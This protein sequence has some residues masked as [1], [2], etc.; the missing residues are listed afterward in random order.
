MIFAGYMWH[1]SLSNKL[2]GKEIQDKGQVL[3]QGWLSVYDEKP[4]SASNGRR[5]RTNVWLCWQRQRW[6]N[7][8]QWVSDDDQSSSSETHTKVFV[9]KSEEVPS[10][11]QGNGQERRHCQREKEKRRRRKET[12][13]SGHS[14]VSV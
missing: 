7:K 13:Q 6:Q 12:D 9:Q 4:S 11:D 2:Q 5:H 8:L 14:V 3:H 10:T 1:R